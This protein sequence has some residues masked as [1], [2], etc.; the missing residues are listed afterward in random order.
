MSRVAVAFACVVVAVSAPF[1]SAPAQGDEAEGS[2]KGLKG[3]F[4]K[5]DALR[6]DL[7]GA[8]G[9]I[10]YKCPKCGSWHKE[11]LFFVKNGTMHWKAV[12][13]AKTKGSVYKV[14][15]VGGTPRW[16]FV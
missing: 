7:S 1:W 3:S 5:K 14:K 11:E 4:I 6:L 8:E 12:D 15:K 10:S 9:A 13:G 16:Y 2:E